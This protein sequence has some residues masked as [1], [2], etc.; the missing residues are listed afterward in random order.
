MKT[1]AGLPVWA[2]HGANDNVVPVERGQQPAD[3][4]NA[5]GGNARFTILTARDHYLTDMYAESEFYDWLLQNY[6]NSK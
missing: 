4:L 2:I 3:A 1:I 6:K 5:Q